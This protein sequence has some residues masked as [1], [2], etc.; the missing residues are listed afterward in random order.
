MEIYEKHGKEIVSLLQEIK[1]PNCG[2][3]RINEL[4]LV[5]LSSL[6]KFIAGKENFKDRSEFDSILVV[7]QEATLHNREDIIQEP[8]IIKEN[9]EFNKKFN[10]SLDISKIESVLHNNNKKL[11]NNNFVDV[12]L[13]F[14][15]ESSFAKATT[16]GKDNTIY[17][18]EDSKLNESK[19]NESGFDIMS[20]KYKFI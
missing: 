17:F 16:T 5:S 19:L 18:D 15:S 3:V 4:L 8:S 6:C 11:E 12:S 9:R 10:K 1:K 13:S 2:K 14:K 7:K 20:E